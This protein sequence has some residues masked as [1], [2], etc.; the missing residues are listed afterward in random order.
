MRD[1]RTRY[2]LTVADAARYLDLPLKTVY[3]LVETRA[4]D[5][6]RTGA[7]RTGRIKFSEAGLER[8]IAAH[9]VTAADARHTTPPRAASALT[10][11]VSPEDLRM[12]Q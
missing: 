12:F 6:L 8:W 1:D 4:I 3:R 5:H 11:L 7:G 10:D 2:R 9:R